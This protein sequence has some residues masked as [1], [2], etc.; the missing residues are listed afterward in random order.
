MSHDG[1][2]QQLHSQSM[3]IQANYN[4]CTKVKHYIIWTQSVQ[5]SSHQLDTLCDQ[6]KHVINTHYDNQW[7]TRNCA[8][9]GNMHNHVPI[10][11]FWDFWT[12]HIQI[13][14][15]QSASHQDIG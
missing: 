15:H 11:L 1:Q 4:V 9:R 8:E 5:C 2:R 6:T 13:I 12:C 7:R 14:E 10:N 3:E